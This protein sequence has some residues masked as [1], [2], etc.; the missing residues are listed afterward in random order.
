[1]QLLPARTDPAPS[2][3]GHGEAYTGPGAGRWRWKFCY[4]PSARGKR[5]SANPG[6]ALHAFSKLMFC[7]KSVTGCILSPR[8]CALRQQ[9][10]WAQG[11]AGAGTTEHLLSCC[12]HKASPAPF[13]PTASRLWPFSAQSDT[14][15]MHRINRG[16]AAGLHHRSWSHLP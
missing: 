6:S 15:S 12:S 1:M 5:C 9:G 4:H 7:C 3:A 11:G 10:L 13:L 8:L 14:R 16:S 2:V